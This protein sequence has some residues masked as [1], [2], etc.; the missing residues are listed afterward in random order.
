[1]LECNE[2]NYK[3]LISKIRPVLVRHYGEEETVA[4]L[5]RMQPIYMKFLA[6]TPFI[7]GKD[8]P[9]S[10]NLDMAIPFFALYEASGRTLTESDIDEMLDI[11]MVSAARAFSKIISFNRIENSRLRKPLYAY[12]TGVANK[13]NSNKGGAWNNTWGIEVNP[14]NHPNGFAMTLVGC[15]LADFA[16]AHGYID[17]LPCLCR[18]DERIAEALHGRLIRHHTVAEGADTCDYWYVGDKNTTDY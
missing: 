11:T 4:I 2:K 18:G 12:I 9:L 17:I 5:E 8:N 3:R 7:G 6:E 1:M 14:E 15:P 16:K 13:L 10:M